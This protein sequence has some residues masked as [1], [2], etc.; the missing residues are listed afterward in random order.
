MKDRLDIRPLLTELASPFGSCDHA[1]AATRR[2]CSAEFFRT[3]CGIFPQVSG[4]ARIDVPI[5]R[6][7]CLLVFAHDVGR[8][9]FH[10]APGHE[11]GAVAVVDL[12]APTIPVR[13]PI[14]HSSNEH[15]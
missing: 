13:R 5:D 8:D 9:D 10:D 12:A 3:F 6:R 7:Q 11:V 14:A 15:F 2:H 1:L 4:D